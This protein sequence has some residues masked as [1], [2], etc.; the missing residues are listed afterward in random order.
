MGTIYLINM[1]HKILIYSKY[2]LNVTIIL[3]PF[4]LIIIIFEYTYNLAI[5]IQSKNIFVNLNKP[6]YIHKIHLCI[7]IGLQ[8]MG[9]QVVL[10]WKPN[11]MLFTWKDENQNSHK[12][13]AM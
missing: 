12:L 4:M 10:R 9:T 6:N 13:I 8:L 7:L 11:K 3:R 5:H 1:L 2:T